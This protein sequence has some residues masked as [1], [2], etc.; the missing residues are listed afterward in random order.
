MAA[1]TANQGTDKISHSIDFSANPANIAYLG[2]R[3]DV[4]GLGAE[5][6]LDMS[7]DQWATTS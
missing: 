4:W 2:S 7:V 6:K 3:L 5:M 1:H